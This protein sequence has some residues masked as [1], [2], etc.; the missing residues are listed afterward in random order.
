MK[1]GLK[2]LQLF[3]DRLESLRKLVDLGL[4]DEATEKIFRYMEKGRKDDLWLSR[5]GITGLPD[6]LEVGGDLFLDGCDRLQSLPEDLQVRGLLS[7]EGCISLT[8]LP[9]GL[10]VGGSLYLNEC[11]GLTR[12]PENLWVG[13]WLHLTDSGIDRVPASAEVKGRIIGLK[14]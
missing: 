1:P 11:T 3:E 12:L 10:R 8:H 7:L 4:A 6:G 5:T 13:E 9:D 14:K 2:Y